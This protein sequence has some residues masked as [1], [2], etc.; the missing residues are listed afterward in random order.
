MHELTATQNILQFVLKEAAKVGA[1][2]VT[3][4]SVKVGEWSTFEPDCIRTSFGIL[5]EGT[6]AQE[7]QIDIEMVAVKYKCGSCGT[8]YVPESGRFSCPK[9]SST[10]GTLISGRE[11]FVDSIEVQNAN[12]GG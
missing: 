6:P 9:C 8:E 12:T 3:R 1:A 5:A 11:I 10:E 2:K 4:I 7:A